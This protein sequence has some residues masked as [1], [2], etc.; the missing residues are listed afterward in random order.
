[1]FHKTRYIVATYFV[2]RSLS[3]LYTDRTAQ[4]DVLESLQLFTTHVQNHHLA[5]K[6]CSMSY[7]LNDS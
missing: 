2:C 1:M 6:P 4:T 7:S 3:V 5:Q